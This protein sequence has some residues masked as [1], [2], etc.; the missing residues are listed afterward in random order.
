MVTEIDEGRGLVRTY[1]AN[2]R[3]RV[4]K[5]EPTFAKLVDDLSPDKTFP[6]YLAYYPWG[7]LKGDTQ[8]TFLPTLDGSYYRLSDPNVPKDVFSHLGYSVN[9]AP[10]ALLLDK[11]LE[12]FIDLKEKKITIPRTV[13]TPGSFFPL[14]LI[15][16][17]KSKR[18]YFTNK[19]LSLTSGVRST[20]MLPNIGC[21]TN[22]IHLQRDFNVKQPPP[23][24]LYEH[25]DI[26]KE[27]V[28]SNVINCDWR[29]CLMYFSEKW[30]KNL[31]DKAWHNLKL[32]LYEL[33]WNHYDYQKNHFYYE[34]IFSIIQKNRNL[35]PN[36]YLVDTAKHLFTTALGIAPGYTP[37]CDNNSLP[38]NTLQTAFVESYLLKKYFPTIMQPTHFSFELDKHTIYYSLQNPSTHIFSPKSRK[39]S[40][41][42][43]ELRELEHIMRVFIEELSRENSLCSDT[44]IHKLVN[45]VEFKYF[46]NEIDRHNIVQ[47]STDIVKFDNRFNSISQKNKIKNAKF[48]SDA[49]F[50]RGCISIRT[51]NE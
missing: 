6:L 17:R 27:I 42:L 2:I 7:A 11:N 33:A 8:S 3:E 37:T 40:S 29:S 13:Y 38:W 10:L 48:S 43:H 44:V 30:I 15:L 9:S 1:W 36:P 18:V 21:A 35:K 34:I 26:F 19:I 28:H 5:V 50:M 24:S 12:L 45:Q 31:F 32:Y 47:P 39:I 16:G 14:S 23:K 4:A 46:H 49:P 22:H 51:K 25:W 20:F 41:T